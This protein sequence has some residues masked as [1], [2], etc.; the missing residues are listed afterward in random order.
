MSR[1]DGIL[2]GQLDGNNRAP[3]LRVDSGASRLPWRAK[4]LA[5]PAS[6]TQK[7]VV[8]VVAISKI[9]GPPRWSAG[10]AACCQQHPE[11]AARR[12]EQ[13]L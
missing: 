5:V 3:L 8:V 13:T 6:L 1:W 10:W 4:A 9:G 7:A 12:S 2:P 11:S